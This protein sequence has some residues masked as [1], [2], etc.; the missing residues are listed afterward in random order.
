MRQSVDARR[1]HHAL[2]R[3]EAKVERS[4]QS[5][6]LPPGICTVAWTQQASTYRD[7]SIARRDLSAS[8]LRIAASSEAANPLQQVTGNFPNQFNLKPE[9]LSVS[10]VARTG[11]TS[12]ST[13]MHGTSPQGPAALPGTESQRSSGLSW[14]RLLMGLAYS[15]VCR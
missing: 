12:R 7:S 6:V 13:T 1:W 14:G 4:C 8:V 10:N 9:E 2:A 3:N 11:L 15:R 5:G